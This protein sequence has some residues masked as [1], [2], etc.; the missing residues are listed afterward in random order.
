MTPES[1]ERLSAINTIVY[2]DW[3]PELLGTERAL[4]PGVHVPY[5]TAAHYRNK[6]HMVAPRRRFNPLQLLKMSRSS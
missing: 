5:R 3:A 4:P 6:Q 2:C 1:A